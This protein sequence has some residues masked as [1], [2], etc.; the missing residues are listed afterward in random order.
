MASQSWSAGE[1]AKH[2]TVIVVFLIAAPVALYVSSGFPILFVLIAA[3]VVFVA[4]R[5]VLAL[6]RASR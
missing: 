4:V 1:I 6:I 3:L 5:I 2:V